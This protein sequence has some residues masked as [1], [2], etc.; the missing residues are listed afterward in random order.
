MT[1]TKKAFIRGKWREVCPRCGRAECGK[2]QGSGEVLQEAWVCLSKCP[3]LNTTGAA[4]NGSEHADA[5]RRA[6]AVRAVVRPGQGGHDAS[7]ARRKEGGYCPNFTITVIIRRFLM[8]VTSTARGV[9]LVHEEGQPAVEGVAVYYWDL[10]MSSSPAGSARN[11]GC[12]RA[13]PGQTV[14]I[15]P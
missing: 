15:S 5:A 9:Y 10:S 11:A 3:T 14:S 2:S 13:R 12:S 1:K 4:K 8:Q 6:Y 7:L